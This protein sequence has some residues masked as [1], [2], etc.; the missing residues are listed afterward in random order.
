MGR[1]VKQRELIQRLSRELSPVRPVPALFSFGVAF[2]TAIALVSAQIF[3]QRHRSDLN[4]LL[5]QPFFWP[6]CCALFL[7]VY[8]FAKALSL[9][10]IPGRS[11]YLT[12]TQWALAALL[13]ATLFLFLRANALSSSFANFSEELALGGWG[14][15]LEVMLLSLLPSGALFL[16]FRARA[17]TQPKF[18]GMLVAL[19]ATLVSAA[20]L[21]ICC[22]NDHAGHLLG[23][24]LVLPLVLASGVGAV[25]GSKIFKW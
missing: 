22:A 3:L 21:Q 10:S 2:L 9:A 13:L 4:M 24:H 6:F 8:F 18:A 20:A 15:A 14:C 11:G 25:I 23:S 12:Y 17:V 16:F 7:S 19:L 1:R 5:S